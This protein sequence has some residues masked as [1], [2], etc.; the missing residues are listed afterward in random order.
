MFIPWDDAFLLQCKTVKRS[1]CFKTDLWKTE[2][3]TGGSKPS[4]C[5]Y[6]I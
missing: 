2:D 1:L 4:K 5:G 3:K 6:G